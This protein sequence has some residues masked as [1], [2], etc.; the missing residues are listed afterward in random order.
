MKAGRVVTVE[1]FR[2]LHH[3]FYK[4]IYVPA[5]SDVAVSIRFRPRPNDEWG[6]TDQWIEEGK[7]LVY[8]GQGGP[9]GHQTWNRF[10]LGL[11]HAAETNSLVYVF[12]EL[13][14][15]PRTYRYWGEWAVVNWYEQFDPSQNRSLIR[16]VIQVPD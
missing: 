1:D 11:R 2:A 7:C 3:D 12:E 8:T 16:F 14:G 6:Y 5:G 9:P 4:G 13:T 15:S 10:N